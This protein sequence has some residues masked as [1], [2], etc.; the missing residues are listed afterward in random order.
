MVSIAEKLTHFFLLH[1]LI[2]QE[3]KDWCHYFL[4]KH[5]Q[6][7]LVLSTLLVVGTLITNLVYAI[8]YCISVLFLQK[9]TNGY[10]SRSEW[11]CALVSIL[12][13]MLAL[14][15]IPWFETFSYCVVLFG[16][17]ICVM[18]LAPVNNQKIHLS[19]KEMHAMHCRACVRVGI[20]TLISVFLWRMGYFDIAKCIALSIFSVD[21]SLAFALLGFGEQ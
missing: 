16:S 4:Q 8:V 3:Q 12:F 21:L 18:L 20:L 7:A 6:S 10:H 19:E 1:G 13:E 17:T 5:I 2:Q 11:L 14:L 15:S 9:R